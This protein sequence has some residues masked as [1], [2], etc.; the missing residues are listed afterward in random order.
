MPELP[1]VEIFRQYAEKHALNKKIKDVEYFDSRVLQTSK[2]M[3]TTSLKGKELSGTQR[4][5]KYLFLR[6]GDRYMVMH[7]GMTGYLVYFK[8]GDDKPDYAQLILDFDND[9]SLAY[10]SKRKLGKIDIIDDIEAYSK[11]NDL[12]IDV[13]DSGFDDFMK[14]M[15]NK[16]GNIKSALMDQSHVSG[17]GNIYADEVLYQEKLHPGAKIQD[18]DENKMKSLFNTIQRV[19]RTAINHKANPDDL[20]DHYLLPHRSEGESCPDCRGKIRKITVSGRSTYFC[21]GCQVKG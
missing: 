8:A 19:F 16:R 6:A 17:I 5:G 11:D 10:I 4:R 3:I 14:A 1:D 21:P 15:K 13:Y 20:P 9:H 7:F 12:G 18:L 2:Q